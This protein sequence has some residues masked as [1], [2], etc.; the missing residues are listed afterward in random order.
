MSISETIERG[1]E[2][3]D[4]ARPI[5]LPPQVV[6]ALVKRLMKQFEPSLRSLAR[7]SPLAPLGNKVWGTETISVSDVRG[8]KREIPV[9][10]VSVQQRG[11][12]GLFLGAVYM[13]RD[14]I[15]QVQMN[16]NLGAGEIVPLL[17]GT[18]MSSVQGAMKYALMHEITHAKDVLRKKRLQQ[19][20]AAILQREDPLHPFSDRAVSK[21]LKMTG[22][23]VSHR[24][25]ARKRKELGVGHSVQ[26]FKD[27]L[28]QAGVLP[29]P[30]KEQRK[31]DA[32][33]ARKRYLNQ[34]EEVKAFMQEIAS[35]VRDLVPAHRSKLVA[36]TPSR[37]VTFLLRQSHT[38][39][40]IQGQ[41]TTKSRKTIKKGVVTVLQDMGVI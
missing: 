34:P 6:E 29:P 40:E 9:S 39:N 15:I 12:R 37:A 30:S 5:A 25:V 16:G 24:L 7:T 26:R 2:L 4:E 1:R 33:A 17:K 11:V 13:P 27:R 14:R 23:E 32:K 8:K 38:W 20:I 19:T 21:L 10:I 3:L 41:L 22:F 31:Q 36:W 35:Q 18:Q 28:S